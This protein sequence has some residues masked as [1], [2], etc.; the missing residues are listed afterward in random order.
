MYVSIIS[1]SHLGALIKHFD[2]PN[3]NAPARRNKSIGISA[4]SYQQ[5]IRFSSF[6]RKASLRPQLPR[7][8]AQQMLVQSDCKSGRGK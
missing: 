3:K 8:E 4:G 5:R 1:A 7:S 6:K 2:V